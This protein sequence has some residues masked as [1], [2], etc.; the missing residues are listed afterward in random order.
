M[1]RVRQEVLASALLIVTKPDTDRVV[2][3]AREASIVEV[4]GNEVGL[5]NCRLRVH[6]SVGS[7]QR[8][9]ARWVR[10]T[11]GGQRWERK[12]HQP[13]GGFTSERHSCHAVK[14]QEP[15]RKD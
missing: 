8:R 2:Q 4:L 3:S 7:E 1:L 14:V 13:R 5:L 15:V 9:L 10:M 12:V 11:T 6:R